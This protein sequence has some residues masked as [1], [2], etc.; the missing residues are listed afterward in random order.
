MKQNT[1]LSKAYA[2]CIHVVMCSDTSLN[3]SIFVHVFCG[4]TF[5]IKSDTKWLPF[6]RRHIQ[7]HPLVST[8]LY[9]DSN[10]LKSVLKSPVNKEPY[11]N[12]SGTI[13]T[14]TI[15]PGHYPPGQTHPDNRHLRHYPPEHYPPSQ[16]HQIVQQ[17]INKILLYLSLHCWHC[18]VNS[19]DEW[20]IY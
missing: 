17:W 16:Y 4:N 2:H 18:N 20:L 9:C 19:V 10:S 7:S 3:E 8:V 11:L 6:Q 14:I 12:G 15:P 1:V 5:I 13:L